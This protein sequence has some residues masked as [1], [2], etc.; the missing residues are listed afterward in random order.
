MLVIYIFNFNN[1]FIFAAI[2]ALK[3][4]YYASGKKTYENVQIYTDSKYVI[5]GFN[6]W[7]HRWDNNGW[8]TTKGTEP[9]NKKLWKWLLQIKKTWVG[10]ITFNYVKAH[11]GIHGNEMAD[12]FANIGAISRYNERSISK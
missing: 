4:I 3:T 6:D 2:K 9:V 7:I 1:T 12:R 5:N 10:D 8:V 11:S